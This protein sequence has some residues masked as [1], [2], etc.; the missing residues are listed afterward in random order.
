M[1][2][3]TL[4]SIRNDIGKAL[5]VCATDARVAAAVNAAQRRLMAKGKWVGTTVRYRICVNEGCLTW[6]RQIETIETFAVCGWPGKIRDQWFEF[7]GTGSGLRSADCGCAHELVDRDPGPTFDWIRPTGKKV[8]LYSD[9]DEAEDAWV[10]IQGYDDNGNW[11]RT[12]DGGIMVEGEYIL[13]TSV[14]RLSTTLF[15]NVTGV[16]K[17]ITNGTLRLYEFDTATSTQRTL[18]IWEPDE[19]RPHYRRS[20]VPGLADRA[21][22]GDSSCESASVTVVAKLRHI[23]VRND[24]DW[25]ILGN[26]DALALMVQAIEKER[27]DRWDEA[28]IYEQNATRLLEEELSSY[29]GDGSVTQVRVAAGSEWAGGGVWN[30]VS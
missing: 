27:K 16:I 18:A 6:P 28:A 7:L 11:V 22:S 25:L 14:G 3:L 8:K 13:A 23:P 2:R 19:E 30:Y 21:T 26:Q 20:L 24:N 1:E 29:L 9:E 12:S 17:P 10:L 15:S 5:G 4:G